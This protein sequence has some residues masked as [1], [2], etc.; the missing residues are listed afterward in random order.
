MTEQARMFLSA[1]IE[2]QRDV[3]RATDGKA[4]FL[5]VVLALPFAGVDV[6]AHAVCKAATLSFWG[7]SAL[8][9]AA[10]GGTLWFLAFLSAIYVI[11]PIVNPSKHVEK[12]AAN[13]H[14]Y[15]FAARYYACRWRRKTPAITVTDHVESLSVDDATLD[16]E[17]AFEHLKLGYIA[18]HKLRWLRV[19]IFL[20]VGA[21]CTAALLA[22]VLLEDRIRAGQ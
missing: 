6:V 13:V 15:F 8:L 14:G 20:V 3:I 7:I 12:G 2:D 16:A 19:T 22:V 11:A 17:L 5:L 1:A 18:A 9:P 4:D 10:I 21:V